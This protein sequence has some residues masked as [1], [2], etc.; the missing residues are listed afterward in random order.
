MKVWF[1]GNQVLD[2]VGAMGY[3]DQTNWYWRMGIY[4]RATNQTYMIHYRNF[5][6]RRT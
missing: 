6:M 4:R 3:D 1:N 2:F 5:N